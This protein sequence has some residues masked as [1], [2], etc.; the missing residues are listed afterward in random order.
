MRNGTNLP[1][2]PHSQSNA[3]ALPIAFQAATAEFYSISPCDSF[4]LLSL[5]IIGCWV[6]PKYFLTDEACIVTFT[7]TKTDGTTVTW[8][9]PVKKTTMEIIEFSNSR[10]F[11]GLTKLNMQS[12]FEFGT[13]TAG[14]IAIDDIVIAR[15]EGKVTC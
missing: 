3:I 7:G 4:N 1:F 14:R 5:W 10:G 15:Q 6:N 13:G 12:R 8:E 2:I 9:R 11:T